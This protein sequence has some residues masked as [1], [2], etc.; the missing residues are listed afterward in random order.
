MKYTHHIYAMI[1][2]ATNIVHPMQVAIKPQI[3]FQPPINPGVFNENSKKYME[4]CINLWN[5]SAVEGKI[6]Q[7]SG[8]AAVWKNLSK[9][10]IKTIIYD[11]KGLKQANELFADLITNTTDTALPGIAAIGQLQLTGA[12]LLAEQ[13]A[14][15]LIQSTIVSAVKAKCPEFNDISATDHLNA[16]ALI[17]EDS[18][19]YNIKFLQS[20]QTLDST[21]FMPIGKGM[22]LLYAYLQQ[23]NS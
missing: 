19:P 1:L 5:K 11:Q 15:V 12:S 6:D 9:E 18:I 14:R 3:C 22:L 7:N 4:Y 21:N 17:G 13:M 16:F 8:L 23:K 2:V 20:N 10:P